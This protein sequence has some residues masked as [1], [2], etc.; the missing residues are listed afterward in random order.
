MV[1]LRLWPPFEH[2]PIGERYARVNELFLTIAN[3]VG[4][5]LWTL[6]ALWWRFLNP[7]LEP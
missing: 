2:T 3:D 1:Q 6:D 7:L 5:D 4:V